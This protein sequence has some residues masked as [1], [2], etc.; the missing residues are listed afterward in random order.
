MTLS[1]SV[2]SLT[3]DGAAEFLQGQITADV[4]QLTDTYTPT[5]ICNLKG[6]VDFGLWIQKQSE[7][8]FDMVIAADCADAFAAHVK[9][10]GAFSKITL[11]EAKPICVA[12]ENNTPTF[13]ETK[14]SASETEWL[15]ASI[16]QG[17]AIIT[18]E[19][20][21]EC[22]PQELRLHQRGGVHYDKGCYLGQEV[23][24]RIWFKA[25]PKAWLHRV[26]LVEN[27]TESDVLGKRTLVL[28]T[29]KTDTGYEALVVARPEHLAET[30]CTIL[31][32]P[33]G[34][35]GSVAREG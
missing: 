28:N 19:L 10:Y 24:A 18:Q 25:A 35:N 17:N 5:A 9:K 7:T 13:S 15:S 29:I 34:L 3:G 16:A 26:E 12:L 20:R 11:S 31:D 33:E 6:R 30:D 14:E 4:N 1:F 32:L 23:V 8:A 2:F 22:Q 21:G 27:P